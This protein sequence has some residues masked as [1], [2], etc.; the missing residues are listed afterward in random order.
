MA[1]AA[2]LHAG[3]AFAGTAEHWPAVL[4]TVFRHSLCAMLSAYLT[5]EDFM[6]GY[7]PCSPG[8][9]VGGD[10]RVGVRHDEW[11]PARQRIFLLALR[12]YQRVGRAAQAAGLA[13]ENCYK[14]RKR[15]PRFREWWDRAL[16][17]EPAT[18]IDALID[19]ATWGM[20]VPLVKRGELVGMV[21]K[22]DA[23]LAMYTLKMLMPQRYGR[24]RAA[25]VPS[26]RSVIRR[27]R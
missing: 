6:E 9:R 24:A 10:R 26:P 1:V 4:H 19:A 11:T 21:R 7:V 22:W 17:A 16:R 14:L 13:R 15:W 8:T 25:K 18:P 2:G 20:E 5:D 23:R 3:T 12:R 27:W